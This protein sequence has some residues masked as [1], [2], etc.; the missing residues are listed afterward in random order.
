MR[1]SSIRESCRLGS[2]R[3]CCRNR[4]TMTLE[5][6]NRGGRPCPKARKDPTGRLKNPR[7]RRPRNRAAQRSRF[8]ARRS[9]LPR[10]TGLGKAAAPDVRPTGTVRPPEWIW[11]MRAARPAPILPMSQKPQAAREPP[12]RRPR[13][14]SLLQRPRPRSLRLH[15]KIDRLFARHRDEPVRS[16]RRPRSTADRHASSPGHVRSPHDPRQSRRRR[17]ERGPRSM[18]FLLCADLVRLQPTDMRRFETDHAESA[19]HAD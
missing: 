1:R 15:G 5:P 12:G 4:A 9:P 13:L 17:C 10:R 14:R 8:P 6:V 11:S 18:M 3:G 7:K 2:F 16:P 19:V